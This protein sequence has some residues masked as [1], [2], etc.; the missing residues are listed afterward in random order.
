MRRIPAALIAVLVVVGLLAPSAGAYSNGYLP[1]SELAPIASGVHCDAPA[2]QL[3]NHA[4]ASYNSMALAAGRQL[5]TDGCDSAYRPFL[6]QVYWRT[7]WCSLGQCFNAATPG[8]SNHGL[9]HA[10]DVPTWV[11]GW[12]R[13]HG[14]RFGWLKTEAFTEPW[15]WTYV[16]GYTRPD[17]GVDLH[18]PT[19]RLHSGGPGQNIY[20]RKV[21]KLLRGHG[22]KTVVVDGAFTAATAKAVRHFQK[23]QRIPVTGVVGPAVWKRLRRPISKPVATTPKEVPPATHLPPPARHPKPHPA[24]PRVKGKAWGIDVSSN[25]GNVDFAGARA[26]G[27]SFAITKATESTNYVNPSFGRAQVRAITSAGLV[28][29]AYD[30]L[31]PGPGHLGKTEAAFFVNAVGHAGF[32]KGWLPPAADIEQTDLSPSGTCH[33]LGEWVHLVAKQLGVRPMVYGSPGFFAS[34]LSGCSWLA[35]Y[36][37]WVASYG[38]SSPQVPAPFV[39][40]NLWQY[41]ASAALGGISGHPFDVSKVRN[42]RAALVRLR[43]RQLPKKARVA[44]RAAL[45]LP[46]AAGPLEQLREAAPEPTEEAARA[47]VPAPEGD[48]EPTAAPPPATP[49]VTTGA[50]S[51][52]EAVAELIHA[53]AVAIGGRG[54]TEGEAE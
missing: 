16:G 46:L 4:A 53:L 20:V 30:F 50:P 28:P 32:G 40:W 43:V 36:K 27:A 52:E 34:Y 5:P 31:D 11:Q 13:L 48:L 6:R 33:Y 49:E 1:E 26:H 12:I 10:V 29:G 17:P 45:D 19:L 9:G 22:F 24:P 8:F 39:R 25:N 42:G 41:T 7:Y 51:L 54:S 18:S 3:E 47:E 23:G 15:H 38:V 44:P 37:L 2:G 14:K 35:H 21:Q